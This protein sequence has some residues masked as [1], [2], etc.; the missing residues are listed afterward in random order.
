MRIKD[1]GRI[2]SPAVA[3]SRQIKYRNTKSTAEIQHALLV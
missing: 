1:Q 3:P 2:I